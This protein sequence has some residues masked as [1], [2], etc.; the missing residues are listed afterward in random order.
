MKRALCG[1][2][3]IA[4]PHPN[5]E[6]DLLN[7]AHLKGILKR[8]IS[9][10]IVTRIGLYSATL[11]RDGSIEQDVHGDV[12]CLPY[13]EFDDEV[14]TKYR[15][16]EDGERRFMQR[17]NGIKTF[18]NA[19]VICD[20]ASLGELEA[21]KFELVITEGEF[22]AMSA[23]EAGYWHSMSVPDGAPPA[24]DKNK[25]LIVVPEDTKDID[26]ENDDKYA[27]LARHMDRL[28]RVKT[29]IIATDDDE[30]GHRLAKEI[31]RRI[32]AARCR[33]IEYPSEPVVKDKKTQELRSCKDLNEVLMHFGSDKVAEIL[34]NSKE[35]P[36]KGLY[37]FSD[38][39]DAGDPVTYEI[40]ISED[41]D[42]LL[43]FYTGAFMVTTGIPGLGKS[44]IT[45]Q[46]AM[47]MAR[48][49]GWHIAIFPGEELPRPFLIS[50]LRKMYLRKPKSEW[51]IAE[52]READEFINEYFK[53]I[54]SDPRSDDD[55]IDV[56][57]IL[58]KAAA[59]V[60]R[61]GVKMLVVDPFNE[62]EH[63]CGPRQSMTEYVGGTIRKFK[64]FG[65]SYDCLVDIVA[66][67]TKLDHNRPGLYSISDSANWA[68]KADLSLVVQAD[69]PMSN[70]RTL[71]VPK[72]RFT[73]FAGRKGEV[74]MDFDEVSEIYV[75]AE[76]SFA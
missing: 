3:L 5:A 20:D 40:G 71:V 12:L 32:G 28:Q 73:Q 76:K 52:K 61:Y 53:L 43:K 72:I 44:A 6:K 45:K 1:T 58:D 31:V 8:G 19:S 57:F 54:Y 34:Q 62:L 30:P 21:G 60:F 74:E 59:A 39:P 49:H 10:E 37:S 48:V 24:R 11:L 65:K 55:D 18:F 23:M 56:D 4:E 70:R 64:R 27:F 63:K 42:K 68:N 15:W 47:Q 36:V 2:A 69:D 25:K 67:P 35:W 7:A 66:H 14:N 13:I 17:K 75:P 29:F 22:D 38:F 51:T 26:P 50:S 33:W 46:I 9:E 41:F 16:L